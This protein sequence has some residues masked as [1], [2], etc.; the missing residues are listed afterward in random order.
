MDG[1]PEGDWSPWLA[2]EQAIAVAPRTPGVYVAR[3]RSTARLV[4]VGM[5]GPRRGQ[6]LR[7]RL[8]VY[9]SG[10]AAVSGLGE[11]ALDRALADEEWLRQMTER[12]CSSGPMRATQWAQAA[13]T[14]ADLEVRFTST[15]DKASAASLERQ[16]IAAINFGLWNRRR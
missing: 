12:T 2:L 10:K 16:V 7:G 11:A 13:L 3:E 14:R 5:A 15:P 4:Y 6:G 9:L 1:L 8:R